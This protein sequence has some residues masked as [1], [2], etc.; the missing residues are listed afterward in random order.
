MQPYLPYE[1]THEGMLQRVSYYLTRQDFCRTDSKPPWVPEHAV[2]YVS[3]SAG[4]SCQ[5]ACWAVNRICEP[6]HFRLLNTAEQLQRH[7]GVTCHG[8][9][10]HNHILYPAYRAD[11]GQCVLQSEPMLYSCVG[12]DSVFT[13]L[14]P[15][16]TYVKEQTAICDECL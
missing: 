4:Q 10:L 7:L 9:L 12:E 2:R 3:S 6:S 14:C 8:T 15:C 1:Y 5:D 11:T 13:R 16:R